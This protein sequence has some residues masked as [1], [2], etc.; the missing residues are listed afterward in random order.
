MTIHKI[1]ILAAASALI[2]GNLAVS[3]RY[4]AIS[5]DP[6]GTVALIELPGYTRN[7]VLTKLSRLH[8]DRRAGTTLDDG[9]VDVVSKLD[10]AYTPSQ[11]FLTFEYDLGRYPINRPRPRLLTI[12][13]PPGAP[14]QSLRREISLHNR[15]YPIAGRIL[16]RA[17]DG[18]A[19]REFDRFVLDP[20]I[21]AAAEHP[22]QFSLLESVN[23][24]L[25]NGWGRRLEQQASPALVP[26]DE[27]RNRLI[28]VRSERMHFS[29]DGDRLPVWQPEPDYF[30]PNRALETV[31][32][33]LLFNIVNPAPKVRFVVSLTETL[34]ADGEN[35][36]PPMSVVSGRRYASFRRRS[37]RIGR[38]RF[39]SP[40]STSASKAERFRSDGPG[41]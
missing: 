37:R 23:P 33:Y 28:Q 22:D 5:T 24:R 34:R 40:T 41:S 10:A 32:R 4:G 39:H 1:V 6:R 12:F 21:V 7:G 25:F 31:G 36:L 20:R 15:N 19:A 30:A 16:L 26:Y 27:V 14:V 38:V 8:D 9:A 18:S 29:L 13:P 11:S 2:A 35:R 3:L 17:S